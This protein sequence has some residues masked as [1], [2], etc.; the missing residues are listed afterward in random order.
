MGHRLFFVAWQMSL[1][2]RRAKRLR[3]F[4]HGLAVFYAGQAPRVFHSL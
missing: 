1:S 3:A 4:A 2:L